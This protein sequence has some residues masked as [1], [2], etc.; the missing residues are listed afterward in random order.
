MLKRHKH[1]PVN[2]TEVEKE[3]FVICDSNFTDSTARSL[4]RTYVI[5]R[6]G[7]CAAIS[8]TEEF[9][10]HMVRQWYEIGRDRPNVSPF[11]LEVTLCTKMIF[12]PTYHELFRL[13]LILNCGRENVGGFNVH[14]I[15]SKN[16]DAVY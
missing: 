1:E 12:F 16:G 8:R 13:R 4:N 9:A 3:R 11:L 6:S 2:F 7:T 5:L 15:N 10:Q 14:K